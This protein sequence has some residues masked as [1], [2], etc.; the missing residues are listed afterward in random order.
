MTRL[1][2]VLCAA[3]LAANAW[4]QIYSYV[5]ANGERV[6]TDRPPASITSQTVELQPTNRLPPQQR[7]I[8]LKP[9]AALQQQLAPPPPPYL[10]LQLLSPQPNETLR[11]SERSIHI[12]AVS[13][14][15]LLAGHS[16]QALLDG[17]PY[18]P[19]SQ[20]TRWQLDDIDRGSHQLQ[21]QLL[22]GTGQ[23]LL[24]SASITVHLHQTSLAERRRIRPCLEDHYGVRPECPLSDKPE[25][26][27]SWWRMGL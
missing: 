10:A 9:P 24:Q 12:E 8:K 23:S 7:L 19:P 4:A 22:D 17:A 26:K 5:D 21:I 3:L 25:E 16:Y 14:P 11:N 13:E 18:G 6:F 20:S 2:F 1:A 27:K 15:S